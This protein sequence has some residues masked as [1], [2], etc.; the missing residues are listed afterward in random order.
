[1]F[2]DPEQV[3]TLI[4]VQLDKKQKQMDKAHNIDIKNIKAVVVHE[5]IDFI[6]KSCSQIEQMLT[7]EHQGVARQFA[8]F[9]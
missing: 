6:K 9:R 3:L 2:D 8:L 4:Q 7:K 5:S 1:M